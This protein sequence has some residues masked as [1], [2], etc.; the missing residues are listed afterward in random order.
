MLWGTS[1]G[2][3]PR[4]VVVTLHHIAPRRHSQTTNDGNRA[5]TT[6]ALPSL[7]LGMQWAPDLLS[8]AQVTSSKVTRIMYS[9][10]VNEFNLCAK[11]Q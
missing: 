7:E 9:F 4:Y 2:L 5:L 10:F 11:N 6:L 1:W 8:N 3:P